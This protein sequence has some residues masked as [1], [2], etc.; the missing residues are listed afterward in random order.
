MPF[1]SQVCG[2][3]MHETSSLA[4]SVIL[5]FLAVHFTFSYGILSVE[6]WWCLSATWF[7]LKD[8]PHCS[9]L[10]PVVCEL[11]ACMINKLYIKFVKVVFG[12]HHSSQAHGRSLVIDVVYLQILLHLSRSFKPFSLSWQVW[13]DIE[14]KFFDHFIILIPGRTELHLG[15]TQKKLINSCCSLTP[16]FIFTSRLISSPVL[17]LLKM[18]QK[19]KQWKWF[20]LQIKCRYLHHSV[21]CQIICKYTQKQNMTLVFQFVF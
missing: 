19:Q 14:I 15:I 21:A 5:E 1:W 20:L 3:E 13:K 17:Q 11:Y 12:S 10:N 2:A 16:Y 6:C 7:P 4:F 9:E 18:W 8:L